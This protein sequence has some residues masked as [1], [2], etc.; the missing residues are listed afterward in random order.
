V[1]RELFMMLMLFATALLG[2]GGAA[3]HDPLKH[4]VYT[5]PITPDPDMVRVSCT[6]VKEPEVIPGTGL[7]RVVVARTSDGF[8]FGAIVPTTVVPA[9]GATVQVSGY[10]YAATDSMP[11]GFL[12]TIQP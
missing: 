10:K 6:V 8:Q 11:K 7:S 2:C 1:K 5:T 9:K 12:F 4:Y 3:P